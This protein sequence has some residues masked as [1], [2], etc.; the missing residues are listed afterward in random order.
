MLT[1]RLILKRPTEADIDAI[2]ELHS[3]PRTNTHNPAGP[4]QTRAAATELFKTW[5]THW[6]EH[7]YGYCTVFLLNEP[8]TVIGFGGVMKK[9]IGPELFDSNLYFR[10]RP[11]AWGQGYAAEMVRAALEHTF[12]E[13]AQ[14][15]VFGS[16]RVHN[17]ASRKTLERA[18]FKYSGTVEDVTGGAPSTLYR[19]ERSAFNSSATQ[20]ESFATCR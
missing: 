6:C 20:R 2:F 10:F 7:G 16:T 19:L 18:S 4:M 1:Q 9:Q 5:D 15:R 12:N 14:E 13:M 17:T 11:E 3:D 8:E